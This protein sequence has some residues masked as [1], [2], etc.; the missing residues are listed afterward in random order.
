MPQSQYHAAAAAT[1]PAAATAAAAA[2]PPS[3]FS[4]SVPVPNRFTA[5][6]QASDPFAQDDEPDVKVKK[7]EPGPFA[8]PSKPGAA[9]AASSSTAAAAAASASV[10]SEVPPPPIT[11]DEREVDRSWYDEATE[12]GGARDEDAGGGEAGFLGDSKTFQAKEEEHRKQAVKKVSARTLARQDD[13]NR[14]EEN[15]MM[16]SGAVRNLLAGDVSLEED[17]G[18]VQ[19]LVH[20]MRPPF[21]DGR[22]VFTTQ[23]AMVSV[24]RDPTSDLAILA[25]QGS[26]LLA[27]VRAKKDKDKMKNK[28]WELAGSKLGSLM[29]VKKEEGAAAGAVADELDS[30]TMTD[31][32]EGTVNYK[33]GSTFAQHLKGKTDAASAF[34]QEKTIRMQREFLPIYT[35]R[36]QLMRVIADSP[37]V[38]IV[39]ETGSGSVSSQ[40]T[41]AAI[42]FEV[43]IC[44]DSLF[45]LFMCS[46]VFSGKR[47]S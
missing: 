42:A 46:C 29:G 15:R 12:E 18:K 11:E 20:D 32:A 37:I 39:G 24:V 9:A 4:G 23:T 41:T 6:R 40:T 36:E 22:V 14:W 34:S 13:N 44:A 2:T 26:P 8:P 33:A 10:K 3:R 17:E 35:C 30:S 1:A 43:T 45:A 25:K 27:E 31:A 19:V 21:L 5:R 16:N 47:L 38:V 28:F 7:E